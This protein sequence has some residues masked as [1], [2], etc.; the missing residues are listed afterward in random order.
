MITYK[1]LEFNVVD[2]G[3]GTFTLTPTSPATSAELLA[4]Y[5]ALRQEVR[6]LVEL[7]QNRQDK[8]AAV[9]ALLEDARARRDE[10][11]VLLENAGEEPDGDETP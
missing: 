8:L 9:N 11:K 4:E 6:R 3:D 2:N 1:D 5:R 7:K 10:I